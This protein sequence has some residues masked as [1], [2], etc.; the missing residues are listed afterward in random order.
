VKSD[1]I[2]RELVDPEF[3]NMAGLHVLSEISGSHLS[4]SIISGFEDAEEHEY[5]VDLT[6]PESLPTLKEW[7]EETIGSIYHV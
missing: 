4:V 2:I 6:D 7:I 5:V 1:R 3:M